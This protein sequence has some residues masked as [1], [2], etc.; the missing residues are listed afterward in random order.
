MC[1]ACVTCG[2]IPHW[3]GF[4]PWSSLTVLG[5]ERTLVGSPKSKSVVQKESLLRMRKR[6]PGHQDPR[7]WALRTCQFTGCKGEK[8]L[9]RRVLLAPLGTAMKSAAICTQQCEDHGH[10]QPPLFSVRE[11]ETKKRQNS[12]SKIIQPSTAKLELVF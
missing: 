12:L 6:S 1:S 8:D 2:K 10:S 11:T 3:R 5:V 7:A 9:G 4:L